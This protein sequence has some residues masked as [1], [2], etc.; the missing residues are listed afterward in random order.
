V[1]IRERCPASSN[2]LRVADVCVEDR[3]PGGSTGAHPNDADQGE[4]YAHEVPLGLLR[5]EG[6]IGPLCVVAEG[7]GGRHKATGDR[8]QAFTGK[9]S[10]EVTMTG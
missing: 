10:S 9:V 8:D 1:Q 6:E 3:E 5:T 2:I 7:P 4:H